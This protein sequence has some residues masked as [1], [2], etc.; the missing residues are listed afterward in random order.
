MFK[1]RLFNVLAM[2]A[3]VMLAVLTI[4][5]ALDTT[6]VVSAADT[7][8]D[9]SLC[10]VPVVDRSSIRSVYEEKIGMWVSRTDSG[11]TGVDGGLLHLLSDYR[12]CSQ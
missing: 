6:K 9:I 11:P 2:A 8:A 10:E 5:Q 1:N 7:P 12:I 3:L 4:Q